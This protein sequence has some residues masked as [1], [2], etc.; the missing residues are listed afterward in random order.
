LRQEDLS[1]LSRRIRTAVSGTSSGAGTDRELLAGFANARDESAFAALVARY[2]RL[3]Q[4]VCRNILG[5]EHDAEEAT[6]AT[7]LLLARRAGYLRDLEVL[8]GWLHGVAYR[9]ALR[10]RRDASRRR[11]RE[12]RERPARAV[13]PEP[14]DEVSCRELHVILDEE[15]QRLPERLRTPFILCCL[16]GAGHGEAARRLGWKT[17]TVSSRLD[18]ARKLL[19][20]RL[21]RRGV[22]LSAV[23]GGLPLAA[24]K[25]RASLLVDRAPETAAAA[26]RY[27]DGG[28]P[29]PAGKLAGAVLREALWARMVRAAMIALGVSGALAIGLGMRP[30]RPE[31]PTPAPEPIAVTPPKPAAPDPRHVDRFGDPLP[32]DAIARFGTARFGHDW[33][34]EST[35]WSPNGKII[36]TLGGNDTS[37]PLSLWDAATG[38]ELRQLAAGSPL[39]AAAFAPDGKTLAT[40]EG[41]RGI[42]LWDVPS[43]KELHRFTS[44]D[45]GTAVAFAP[46]GRTL[47]AAYRRGVIRVL[48]LAHR[49]LVVELKA[50]GDPFLRTVAYAPDG[51]TLASTGDDGAVILWDLATGTERWQK[52]PHGEWA[53]GLAFSPDGKTLATTGADCIIRVWDVSRGENLISFGKAA[54]HGV[55]IAYSPDGRTLASPGPADFVCLWDPSTGKEKGHWQTGERWHHSVSYSPDGRTLATTGFLGSRVRL[56]DPET[57]TERRPAVGHNGWV[58]CL[59]FSPDGGTVWSAATDRVLFQWDVASGEGQALPGVKAEASSYFATAFSRDGRTIAT[60]GLDGN[61]RLWDAGGHRQATLTGHAG[62]VVSVALSP[63]GKVVASS[64][65][66]RTVRFW[67]V[68]THQELRRVELPADTRACLTFSADGR[69]LALARGGRLGPCP[70]PLVLDV[71]TGNEIL[72]LEPSASAPVSSAVSE[73]FV[74]FSPDGSTL[75]TVGTCGDSVVRLWDAATGK[76]IGRCGGATDCR[77]WYCLAFSPD[78][79]LLATGPLDYDDTVHLWEVATCQEVTRLRGH[80]GGITALA[81]SPDG[82]SLAS[83]AGDATVLIWDLTGR[84]ASGQRST[85]RLSPSRLEECWK[86]LGGADAPAAYRAVRSLAADPVRSVPFLARRLRLTEPA[87]PADPAGLVDDSFEAGG[88]VSERPEAAARQLTDFREGPAFAENQRRAKELPENPVHAPVYLRE[89]RAVMALEYAATPEARRL[90]QVLAGAK[91]E[92]RLAGEARGALTR[93][94]SLP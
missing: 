62:A 9:T 25:G 83:G 40:A 88:R 16:E 89:R 5:D 81:F 75:A 42:V 38:R 67:D 18:E 12:A 20:R 87:S 93:L 11:A 8:A 78:G 59:A 32:A 51:K 64:G 36:A 84:I 37:R 52:K 24:G 15:L 94:N 29:G 61:L 53:W 58:S 1:A 7:F 69:K 45:D 17:G 68:A 60:A 6:Q 74:R 33:Y 91:V 35:V 63:D 76:M 66:D 65:L 57:G 28:A 26:R 23:L 70:A 30:W 47:A 39:R 82:R 80:R 54:I 48:E 13:V 3:V 10:A 4:N 44:P 50:S 21:A 73:E 14:V 27:V 22:S 19:R 86:D 34:T 56:W 85:D 41:K 77:L 46:D 71:S 49:R 90:L 43:G 92:S 79:R 55:L 31:A 72:R 2:G